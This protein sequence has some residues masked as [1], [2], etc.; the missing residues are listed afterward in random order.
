MHQ[1]RQ[2]ALGSYRD[3]ILAP[4]DAQRK[5]D[6]HMGTLHRAQRVQAARNWESKIERQQ[7]ANAEADRIA[8]SRRRFAAMQARQDAARRTL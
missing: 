2:S 4:P 3:G 5:A 6:E 1:R 7:M 8:E